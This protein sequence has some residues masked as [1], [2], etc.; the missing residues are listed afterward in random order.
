MLPVLEGR[1]RIVW[2]GRGGFKDNRFL[3]ARFLKTR[4]SKINVDQLLRRE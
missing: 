3:K 1:M 2:S 4:K